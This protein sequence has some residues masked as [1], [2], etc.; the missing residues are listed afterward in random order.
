MIDTAGL[1]AALHAFADARDWHRYHTPKNLAMALSVEVAELVEI[2][3]W[4]TESEASAVMQSGE[5]RHVEQE[6][7]DIAMYL[8]RLSSVLGV[9]LNR[10]IAEKLVMNARKYPAPRA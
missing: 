5:A 7:A 1:D 9:D 8:V 6:L 3:Q 10:A 2:F 4:Q